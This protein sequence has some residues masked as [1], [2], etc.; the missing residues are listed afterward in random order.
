MMSPKEL[1]A[2][3]KQVFADTLPTSYKLADGTNVTIS[4][5]DIGGDFSIGGIPAEAGKYSL[6][7]G[8]NVVV[9]ST[10]KITSVE[11]PQEFSEV[12]LVGG[13][14]CS[15]AKLEKGNLVKQGDQPIANGEYTLQDGNKFVTVDG[16]ITEIKAAAAKT[17]KETLQE[18]F[19]TMSAGTTDAGVIACIK[20]LMDY[21]FGWQMDDPDAVE[22]AQNVADAIAAVAT[23]S[24]T[25]RVA[26]AKFTKQE[27]EIAGLKKTIN[28][29]A[30]LMTQLV[31]IPAGDP[32]TERKTVFSG[33]GATKKKGLEKYAAAAEK[34]ATELHVNN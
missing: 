10:G 14:K 26:N 6:Q 24:E 11:D 27:N 30:E 23:M 20:A 33:M 21:C 19:D 9:D 16:L 32:P 34:L 2:A 8:T 3:I 29:M 1:L 13:V 4:L 31:E 5:L 25:V 7:D 12:E 18:Q 15:F 28:T 22:D 17:T